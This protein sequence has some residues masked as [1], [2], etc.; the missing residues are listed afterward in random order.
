MDAAESANNRENSTDSC[1][2]KLAR[3]RSAHT[4]SDRIVDTRA[5]LDQQLQESPHELPAIRL[6][7]P[8]LLDVTAVQHDKTNENGQ[9]CAA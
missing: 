7:I 1:A 8:V 4:S 5:V 3:R 9:A 2:A 6:N